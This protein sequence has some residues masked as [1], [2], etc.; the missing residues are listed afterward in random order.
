MA[1]TNRPDQLDY[2]TPPPPTSRRH[3]WVLWLAGGVAAFALLLLVLW[4][5]T[6]AE[7]VSVSPR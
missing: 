7:T 4:F 2:A 1:E 3:Q 5:L 6:R